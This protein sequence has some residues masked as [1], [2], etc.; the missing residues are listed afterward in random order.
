MKLLH[1]FNDAIKINEDDEIFTLKRYLFYYVGLRGR[2]P[3]SN[4][5]K[6]PVFP[7]LKL[8]IWLKLSTLNQGST[9][10]KNWIPALN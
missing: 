8:A 5:Y 6:S 3:T 4:E 7:V 2:K 1:V 10:R 9:D